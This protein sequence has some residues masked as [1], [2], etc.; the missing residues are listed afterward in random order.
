MRSFAPA[1]ATCV[2][3]L[4]APFLA[5]SAQA[6]TLDAAS[7]LAQYNLITRGDAYSSQEVEGA[8]YIGGNLNG[9]SSQAA[10]L[11]GARPDTG[12]ADVVVRGDLNANLNLQP[13]NSVVVGGALNGRVNGTQ[14]V[15]TGSLPAD[16]VLDYDQVVGTLMAASADLAA[17]DA[18][19]TYTETEQGYVFGAGIYTIDLSRMGKN[20]LRFDLAPGAVTILNV[21]GDAVYFQKN[22]IGTASS[23]GAQIIWNFYDASQVVLNSK[24][25]GAVLA[26]EASV[27]SFSGSTEGSVFANTIRQTNGEIHYQGFS[28]TL[29]LASTT[30]D[31]EVPLPAVPLPAGLP[32]MIGALAMLGLVSR[33]RARA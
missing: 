12:L 23:L 14:D 18:T 29:P 11:A 3:M 25:I 28:A 16:S 15:T 5:T 1:L 22:I 8:I 26:P 21:T 4:A 6:A 20:E 33:K 19:A 17:L 27:E 13:S 31:P 2:A 32:L 7:L 10:F 9:S 24:L 30:P